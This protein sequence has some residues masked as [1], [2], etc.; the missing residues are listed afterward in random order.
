MTY[1]LMLL[2]LTHAES[3]LR[4]NWPA[5]VK[6]ESVDAAER[7]HLRMQREGLTRKQLEEL[8]KP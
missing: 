3:R 1:Q 6:A 2:I 5:D 8:A 4:G 7:I